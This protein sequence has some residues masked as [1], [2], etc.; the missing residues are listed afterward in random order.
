MNADKRENV[1][2]PHSLS[3]RD[4]RQLEMRGITDVV[5][6]DEET[7]ELTTECGN[8]SIEGTGLHVKVL[9]LSEGIVTFDGTVNALIYTDRPHPE[10]KEKSGWFGKWFR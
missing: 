4:R 5:S 3:M 6:F 9:N 2:M 10:K 7:A 8:L 1:P